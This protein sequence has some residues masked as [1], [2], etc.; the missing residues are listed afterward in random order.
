M[1]IASKLLMVIGIGL[2]I[3]YLPR[4]TKIFRGPN[5]N[6][7][8]LYSQLNTLVDCNPQKDMIE[9]FHLPYEVDF[10]SGPNPEEFE[11]IYAS[12]IRIIPVNDILLKKEFC[13]VISNTRIA[14]IDYNEGIR[15][16][17]V[18]YDANKH[19]KHSIYISQTGEGRVD[20]KVVA[21]QGELLPWLEHLKGFGNISSGIEKFIVSHKA[22]TQ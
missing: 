5:S 2:A 13:A 14:E 9:I 15:W 19:K 12:K 10:F 6:N 4:M 22:K 16:E 21:I 18:I 17:C 1:R 11:S 20:S 8:V 3:L 7:S